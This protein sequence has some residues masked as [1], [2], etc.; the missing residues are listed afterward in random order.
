MVKTAC[1]FLWIAGLAAAAP[2]PPPA[3][4]AP[5]LARALLGLPESAAFPEGRAV[6]GRGTTHIR[7]PQAIDGIP[8]E[9]A[10]VCVHFD[11][12]GRLMKLGSTWRRDPRPIRAPAIGPEEAARRALA[13]LASRA[14]PGLMEVEDA[15]LIITRYGELAREVRARIAEPPELLRIRIDGRTG[16]ILEARDILRRADGEGRVFIPNPVVTLEDIAL[17]DQD[18]SAAAVAAEAYVTVT[19]PDLDLDL[20]RLGTLTGPYVSTEGTPNRVKEPSLRFLYDRSH[21]GFEEVMVYYH[22]DA[23]ARLIHDLGFADLGRRRIQVFVNSQPP[24]IPLTTDV[25]YFQPTG[26]R[27]GYIAFGSGGVDDAEDGEIIVHEYGHAIQHEQVP[28]FG[29]SGEAEAIGEGFCDFLATGSLAPWSG[30]FGDDCFGEWD[31]RGYTLGGADVHCLRSIPSLAIYPDDLRGR[32]HLDGLIYASALWAIFRSLGREEALSLAIEAN[33]FLQA[34]ARFRDLGPAL[35]DADRAIHDGAHVGA[36]QGILA[37][38]GLLPAPMPLAGYAFATGLPVRI[39]DAEP[40]GVTSDVEWD[41]DA[42]ILSGRS[43]RVYVDID[44]VFPLDIEA[45]LIAPDGTRLRLTPPTS[46]PA[47]FGATQQPH[48]TFDALVGKE[49]RGMWTLR[50]V[51]RF[52][53]DA[54]SLEAWGIHIA[55]LVRGEA[56][57][58]GRIDLA[59]PLWILM[60][61]FAD[62]DIACETVADIDDDGRLDLGDPIRLLSYIFGGAPPAEP[63]VSP[64]HDPTPDDLRCPDVPGAGGL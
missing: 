34:S 16:A 7:F 51:D 27:T 21:P 61:L 19:L 32:P 29:E 28:Y 59:D 39:P 46:F 41:G 60:Y 8:V 20:A 2:A 11:A 43:V 15:G 31:A 54:G 45:S 38:R 63:F 40:Q 47:I 55:N 44:H 62:G 23:T 14:K 12:H 36:L 10:E 52:A 17:R 30:G 1:A 13:F 6:R 3:D 9:G 33:F 64:G 26:Q 49:A 18:N 25:S 5:G 35:L 37:A 48:D 56:N 42:R 4:S 57:G 22:I 24:G 58:D 53:D 50:V